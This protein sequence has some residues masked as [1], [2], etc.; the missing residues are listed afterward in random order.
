M[1]AGRTQLPSLPWF[2]LS[3]TLT[4]ELAGYKVSIGI[5]EMRI[6]ISDT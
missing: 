3:S 6:D 5:L 1:H 2:H 4:L